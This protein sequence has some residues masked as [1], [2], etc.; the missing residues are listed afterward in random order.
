MPVHPAGAALMLA[1][2]AT[3]VA[4]LATELIARHLEAPVGAI[5][6]SVAL[7]VAISALGSGSWAPTTAVYALV[8][9]EY[10]VALQHS[11]LE[12]RRT[13]FQSRRNRR[14]QLVAGGAIAGAL[15]V[16]IA[17]TLGPGVPGARGS[18]WI[19]YRSLGSGSGSNVLNVTSPL[20]SVKAKLNGK[21]STDEV[22]TVRTTEPKGNYWRVIAL[23][24]FQDDG[25]GLNSDQRSAT[26]LP[27]ATHAE[28]TTV[29]NQTFHLANIDARWLPAAYRPIRINVPGSQVLPGSTSLFLDNPLSGLTYDVQSEIANPDKSVLEAV[30]D[31]D[32]QAMS[33]NLAL[34]ANFSGK[35]RGYAQT[36]TAN[37]HTPYDKALALMDSFRPPV[38]SYDTTVDLGTTTNALDKFLFETHRG[39]CEQYAAAFAE[40]ARSVGLPTR[41]AVGYQ[42]GTLGKDGLWH[43]QEKDAHAWPEVWLGPTVGWYRFEPTP[44]RTDP[45][46]GLGSGVIGSGAA[47]TTSTT[48]PKSQSTTPTSASLTPT[49]APTNV[50]IEPPGAGSGGSRTRAHVVTAIFVV[51]AIAV[52]ALAHVRRR[53]R[54][55]C[56]AADAAAAERPGQSA[57]RARRMDRSARPARRRGSE[58][59]ARDHLARIRDAPS[60]RARG[61]SRGS[62]AHGP[63]A[64]AH[65]GHVLAR[66]T[67]GGGSRRGLVGVRRDRARTQT[68]RPPRTPVADA[69]VRRSP[70]MARGVRRGPRRSRRRGDDRTRRRL[71]ELA[72]D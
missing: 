34:P 64:L 25:W 5:G 59:S 20:V 12:T 69:L 18:A 50:Q 26:K 68:Q 11:E 9:I 47:T 32:L 66:D 45:V 63:G 42:R 57:P 16:A 29:V 15:V 53:A 58:S 43:V 8:V 60:P 6:P 67:D 14:S 33:A 30:D 10:L 41:V 31:A 7:F 40:L 71:G 72:G 28:G 22:F 21:Q 19:K 65:R 51:L 27:G 39:F 24:Q 55:R 54:V 62:A 49:S 44:G 56:V 36:V 52:G 70:T 13:W 2:M 1:V 61:R 4:A 23:D 35:A 46:T 3:F 48:A 38:F 17:V 37:A